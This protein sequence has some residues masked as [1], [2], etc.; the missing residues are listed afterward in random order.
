M[1]INALKLYAS[2]CTAR[3][4]LTQSGGQLRSQHALEELNNATELSVIAVIKIIEKS[5]MYIIQYAYLKN[6]QSVND[7]NNSASYIYGDAKS[8]E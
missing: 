5:I 4:I 6:L 8:K 1:H 2:N 3:S 7:L